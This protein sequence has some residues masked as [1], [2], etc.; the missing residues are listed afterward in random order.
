MVFYFPH[1]FLEMLDKV[2]RLEEAHNLSQSRHV[3][4]S[5]DVTDTTV[6]SELESDVI[7]SST[8]SSDQE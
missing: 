8:S 3:S 4:L 5:T 7:R 6:Q 1:H 2:D